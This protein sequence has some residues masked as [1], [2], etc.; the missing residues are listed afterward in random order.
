MYS[1]IFNFNCCFNIVLV[2]I[3]STYIMTDIFVM[4]NNGGGFVYIF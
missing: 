2:T 4:D 3:L 1:Y